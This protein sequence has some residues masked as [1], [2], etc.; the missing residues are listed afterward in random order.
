MWL[1]GIGVKA[2]VAIG[3]V[4]VSAAGSLAQAVSEAAGNGGDVL[5]GWVGPG[6]DGVGVGA[7]LFLVRGMYTG[8][9]VSRST[10]EDISERVA[11]Q[12]VD[13]AVAAHQQTIDRVAREVIQQQRRSSD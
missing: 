9:L 11:S 3:G 5:P 6:L 4:A 10:I 1:S 2:T 13:A 12:A 7:V 8:H